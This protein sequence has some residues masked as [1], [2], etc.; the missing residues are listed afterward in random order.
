MYVLRRVPGGHSLSVSLPYDCV[1]ISVFVISCLILIVIV[2]CAVLLP[3]LHYVYFAPA[4]FSCVSTSSNHPPVYMQYLPLCFVMLWSIYATVL[5]PRL[6]F[7]VFLCLSK[8]KQLAFSFPFGFVFLLMSCLLISSL[9]SSP[10]VKLPPCL[11]FWVL[12]HHT[13]TLD[14]LWKSSVPPCTWLKCIQAQ[15]TT[16]L[17]ITSLLQGNTWL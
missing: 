14:T 15:N 3:F 12:L 11:Q 1:S 6:S 13:L 7:W 4:V 10:L 9:K 16:C 17:C 8:F 5:F 2:S